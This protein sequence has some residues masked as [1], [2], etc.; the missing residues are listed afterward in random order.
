MVLV[1]LFLSQAWPFHPAGTLVLLVQ[2]LAQGSHS[3]L[4]R[5]DR[6]HEPHGIH[7]EAVGSRP[8]AAA[9]VRL[10]SCPGCQPGVRGG[11]GI[12]AMSWS[13]GPEPGNKEERTW[14]EPPRPGSSSLSQE[15]SPEAP[16]GS[17][18]DLST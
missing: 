10:D 3:L 16:V 6:G 13:H 1:P 7:H 5:V 15:D 14:W 2:S 9:V 4:T 11:E 12:L 18:S 17:R 8:S